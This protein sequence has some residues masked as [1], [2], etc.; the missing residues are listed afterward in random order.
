MKKLKTLLS[1]LA[2]GVLLFSVTSIPVSAATNGKIVFTATD[3]ESYNIAS[4]KSDGSSYEE[5][6]S[7]GISFYPS[8]TPNGQKIVFNQTVEEGPAPSYYM[9]SDGTNAQATGL[10][11][12]YATAVTNSLLAYASSEFEYVAA[13]IDG[14][15]SRFTGYTIG[16]V[17]EGMLGSP[18]ISQA[19]NRFTYPDWFGDDT[20]AIYISDLDGSNSIKVSSEPQQAASPVLSPDGSKVYYIGSSDGSSFDLYSVNSDGSNETALV[21]LPSAEPVSLRIS[22]DG[23]KFVYLV[24]GDESSTLDAYTMDNDGSGQTQV[25]DEIT[26]S[27]SQTASGIGWSPDAN[28]LVFSQNIGENNWDIFT[29]NADGTNLTNLTNTP[30]VKEIIAYTERAWG[31]ATSSPSN[32]ATV[33]S[34]NGT[35]ITIET[36]SGTTITCSSVSEE[37]SA[38]SDD[39]NYTYPLDLVN[40]CFDTE[41]EDNTVTLTFITDLKP[42]EVTPRKY[43]PNTKTYTTLTEASVTE[44]EVEGQHALQLTYTITDNGDL[45]LNPEEGSIEDPVGL[46]TAADNLASTGQN[47]TTYLTIATTLTTLGI[48]TTAITKRN[49]KLRA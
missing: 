15:N 13:N 22:P 17:V 28:K 47:I 5:L 25:L 7:D 19:N 1:S 3:G 34:L 48:T 24:T 33:T 39:T 46:A 36:P 14:T 8:F 43:N 49:R 18:N 23:S 42:N 41:D 6:T 12:F 27:D 45:D 40:F 4:I 37:A 31:A 38:S 30:D 2:A 29:V 10:S 35:E 21:D 44:T 26:N 16:I 20:L 32:T 9:N 11:G